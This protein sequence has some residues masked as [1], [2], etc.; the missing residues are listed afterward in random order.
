VNRAISQKQNNY[1][2]S[3]FGKFIEK[4]DEVVNKTYIYISDLDQKI[5]EKEELQRKSFRDY[6]E[7]DPKVT[8]LY[9]ETENDELPTDR[10]PDNRNGDVFYFNLLNLY[11]GNT[12]L[13]GYRKVIISEFDLAGTLIRVLN[14]I[15]DFYTK[16]KKFSFDISLNTDEK[17][18]GI[19]IS[20]ELLEN[21]QFPRSY[22]K[23]LI[24]ALLLLNY[25][26][27][28]PSSYNKNFIKENMKDIM[29]LFEVII[30][31]GNTKIKMLYIRFLSLVIKNNL[32]VLISIGKESITK[33][34][35]LF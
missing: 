35:E 31:N 8:S 13:Y 28:K 25:I 16:H 5:K 11:I 3:I 26:F 15:Y 20:R 29:K 12:D 6:R 9:V 33:I 10:K 14:K 18:E 27:I 1:I 32:S 4:I 7:Q 34:F 23:A 24:K 17:D 2:Q 22:C 30:H 21:T 19:Q